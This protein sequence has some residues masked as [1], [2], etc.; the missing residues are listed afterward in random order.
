MVGDSRPFIAAGGV[1][2]GLGTDCVSVGNVRR[3]VQE[4]EESKAV[5][6]SY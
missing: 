2:L 6:V 1:E 5:V 4:F 3:G